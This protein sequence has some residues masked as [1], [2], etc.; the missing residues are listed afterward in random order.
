MIF[1]LIG[2]FCINLWSLVPI[3]RVIEE[4]RKSDKGRF[5]EIFLRGLFNLPGAFVFWR[6]IRK[7]TNEIKTKRGVSTVDQEL[8]F[9]ALVFAYEVFSIP[10]VAVIGGAFWPQGILLGVL[11]ILFAN[12]YQ[13]SKPP[14]AVCVLTIIGIVSVNL[15]SGT[16]DYR[17]SIIAV[18]LIILNEVSL[19]AFMRFAIT[20]LGIYIV[21]SSISLAISKEIGYQAIAVF[22]MRNIVTYAMLVFLFYIGKKQLILVEKLKRTAIEL[23]EKNQQMEELRLA[24]ERNRIAREIH[25]TLGHTLTGALIQLEAARKVVPKDQVQAVAMIGRTQEVIREGF[26]DVKRAIRALRPTGVEASTIQEALTDL[27]KRAENELGIRVNLNID[28]AV[29]LDP[30]QRVAVFRITQEGITNSM[31]H[32]NAAEIMIEL[33]QDTHT[34]RLVIEDNGDGCSH[35]VEG[36]GLTGIRERVQKMEGKMTVKSRRGKG[37]LMMIC[38]PGKMK[39]QETAVE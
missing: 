9:I 17:M 2:I 18:T 27:S 12:H 36:Y 26:S 35:I 4:D 13:T 39:E 22:A 5:V 3:Y 29:D 14:M 10:L 23:K 30:D 38:L 1:Y 7:T 32:G 11:F 16:T 15:W 21:M 20:S 33:S 37:F 8:L 19:K 24:N 34:V 6:L 28:E 25:D 31:R